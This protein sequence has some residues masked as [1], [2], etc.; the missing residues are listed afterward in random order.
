MI[1]S[2][3][4]FWMIFMFLFLVPPIGYGWG[5]QA[6]DHH[7]GNIIKNAV[8]KFLVAASEFVT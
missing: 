1:G 4:F 5:T 3:W 8:T 6:G 7:N 2:W